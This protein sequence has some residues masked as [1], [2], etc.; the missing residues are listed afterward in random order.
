MLTA[1]WLFQTPYQTFLMDFDPGMELQAATFYMQDPKDVLD[2]T[3]GGPGNISRLS[4]ASTLVDPRLAQPPS[5]GGLAAAEPD[6][7]PS[8]PPSPAKPFPTTACYRKLADLSARIMPS[9][10]NTNSDSQM[11][12]D[13]V[14]F[15]GELI[16]IARQT[17]PHV[18][19]PKPPFPR[20]TCLSACVTATASDD[21][22]LSI[23]SVCCLG[24][25][26]AG[27]TDAHFLPDVPDSAVIFLLLGCYT[28]ILRLLEIST[29][30]LWAQ[31]CSD[32]TVSITR[33][34]N[35]QNQ[36]EAM[37]GAIGPLLEAS[38]A[39][40]TVTYLVNRLNSAFDTGAYKESLGW[41]RPFLGGKEPEGDG[42]F[43]KAFI[44]IRQREQ[45]L[46]RRTQYLQQRI[47]SKCY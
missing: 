19:S 36:D 16:D 35:S 47:N 42:L 39:V 18:Y 26:N 11:L 32:S 14:G 31:H 41:Q 25:A 2:G 9:Y 43:G 46:M 37:S 34:A 45:T 12:K 10:S 40:H 20:N 38:L 29:N 4:P 5:F 6:F 21:G 22:E 3:L 15:C 28:Q 33:G 23:D 24:R 30:S 44:E 8:T 17:I 13:V 7:D 1:S 27:K